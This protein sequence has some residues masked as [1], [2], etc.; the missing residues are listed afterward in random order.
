MGFV[1]VVDE[2]NHLHFAARRGDGNFIDLGKTL[3]DVHKRFVLGFR[4][5]EIE[6]DG[7]R[8]AEHDEHQEGKGLQRLLHKRNKKKK[9]T[10]RNETDESDQMLPS[11]Q[12]LIK[13]T[14]HNV[15]NLVI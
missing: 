13:P 15:I 12:M 3:A 5:D 1:R 11:F 8:D 9:N 2:Q 7:R 10:G 14:A 6:V 4:Q